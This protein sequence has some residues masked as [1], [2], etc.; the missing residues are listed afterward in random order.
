MQ[1]RFVLIA[2]L[3]STLAAGIL[4]GCVTTE[5]PAH[6]VTDSTDG[7]V[8]YLPRTEFGIEVERELTACEVRL[9][10]DFTIAAAWAS[11]Q[12]RVL[13]AVRT[14]LKDKQEAGQSFHCDANQVAMNTTFGSKLV[15]RVR[16]NTSSRGTCGSKTG[17]DLKAENEAALRFLVASFLSDPSFTTSGAE[18]VLRSAGFQPFTAGQDLEELMAVKSALPADNLTRVDLQ[19]DV[20][21]KIDPFFLADMDR[22]YTLDYAG[23]RRSLKKT[24]YAVETYDNGTLKSINA[25]LEDKTGDVI[26]ASLSGVLKVAAAAGGIPLPAVVPQAGE[27]PALRSYEQFLGNLKKKKV[28][29]LCTGQVRTQLA[30][31]EMLRKELGELPAQIRQK[32]AAVA[33]AAEALSTAEKALAAAKAAGTS[34]DALKPFEKEVGDRKAAHA[35]AEAALAGQKKLA[36][37]AASKLARVREALTTVS[38]VHFRPDSAPA[39]LEIGGS[40]STSKAWFD[41]VS[42][43]NY[44]KKNVALCET[45]TGRPVPRPLLVWSSVYLAPK[46]ASANGKQATTGIVYRQPARGLLIVCTH[47]ECLDCQG[48][49]QVLSDHLVSISQVDVPQLG[50]LARLP[51]TNKAFQNN[52]LKASFSPA[53]TLTR[54]E[55]S[56]NARA[57]AQAETFS[58]SAD[59]LL[60]FAKAT[61]ERDKVNLE[62]ES[63]EL[64][65]RTA[66][67]QKQLELEQALKALEDFRA[68]GVT[69][70][71]E[72]EGDGEDDEQE[73]GE[74]A[75]DDT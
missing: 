60:E 4:T 32:T 6:A 65:A 33:T 2:I 23:T 52:S 45:R 28:P 11:E 63:A 19:V 72:G 22:A 39:Q 35:A 43:Q 59:S 5:L 51:L 67:V 7:Q 44:C 41:D 46:K 26:R 18:A 40:W 15:E 56:S 31:R 42:L 16:K 25:G 17:A 20:R 66:L 50:I 34:G 30:E 75:G 58:E 70:E 36:E 8:Y 57:V 3:V 1:T 68:D 29:Q 21:A 24:E 61:R 71:D 74:G 38:R 47:K 27:L 49:V 14:E 10:D 9:K 53:G 69:S 55:Y 13:E 12:I 54:V 62:N 37:P 64:A 73:S 48:A